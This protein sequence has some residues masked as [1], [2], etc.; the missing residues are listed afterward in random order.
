MIL[1]VINL[2]NYICFFVYGL[3]NLILYAF[4]QISAADLDLHMY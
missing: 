3:Y 2:N 4:H 1:K